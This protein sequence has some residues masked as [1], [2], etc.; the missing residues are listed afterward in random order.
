VPLLLVHRYI[1]KHIV[2]TQQLF[3]YMAKTKTLIRNVRLNPELDAMFLAIKK[4]RML[5]SDSE[6]FRMI[7]AHYYDLIT[8]NPWMQ[9]AEQAFPSAI[10]KRVEHARRTTD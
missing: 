2:Y 8:K 5:T 6:T 9:W 4:K 7:I 1:C 3:V 10:Q